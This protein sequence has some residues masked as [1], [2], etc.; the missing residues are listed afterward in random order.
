MPVAIVGGGDAALDEG[1]LHDPLR[2]ERRRSSTAAT[3][4]APACILQERAL[5]NPKMEFAWNTVVEEIIGENQVTG[6]S[7]GTS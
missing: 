5:A 1:H 7:C 6:C 2:L 3:S 4:C